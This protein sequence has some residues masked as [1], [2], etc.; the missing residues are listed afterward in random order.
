M[1][2]YREAPTVEGSSLVNVSPEKLWPSATDIELIASLSTEL[3]R[4]R[5]RQ[6]SPTRRC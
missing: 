3:Q 2:R 6:R 5:R 4:V 1:T